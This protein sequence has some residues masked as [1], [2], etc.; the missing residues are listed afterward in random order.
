MK[1]HPREMV[2]AEAKTEFVQTMLDIE[3]KYKLTYGEMF[4]MLGKRMSRLADDLVSDERK[5]RS[6]K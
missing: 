3:K 5:P 2:V 4:V 1:R 6:R